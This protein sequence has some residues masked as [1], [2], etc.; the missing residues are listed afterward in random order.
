MGNR[1]ISSDI[2]D[3]ALRLWEAGWA[4][5]DICYVLRVSPRSL[6]RWRKIFE[7]FGKATKPPSLLRGRDHIVSLAVLTAIRAVFF[8]DPTVMLDELAWH[9]AINHDIAISISAL[10]A[11]LVR[12]GLTRKVLQKVASERDEDRREEYRD[13]I[14]N[15]RL[16]FRAESSEDFVRADRYTLTAALSLEGYIA[17]RI[18]L[19]SMDAYEFFDFIVEDVLPQMKPYPDVQSVLVLDNCRIHHTDLLQEVLNE[20]G[21]F[22]HCSALVVPT[23]EYF[24]CYALVSP[25][26]LP[27]FESHRGVLLDL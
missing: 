21:M 6:Y 12:A 23:N 24:R 8:H 7:E 4:T 17:T 2:K 9:L 27:R 19:G 26:V 25:T 1:R 11:T 22:G 5:E 13:C 10:Q 14:Q 20:N 15:P 18:V 16:L 3:C